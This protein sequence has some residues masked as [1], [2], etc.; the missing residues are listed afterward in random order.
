MADDAAGLASIPQSESVLLTLAARQ[1]LGD[2]APRMLVP[3]SSFVARTPARTIAS[4]LIHHNVTGARR[5]A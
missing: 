3:L 4:L 2:A 5:N 1:R